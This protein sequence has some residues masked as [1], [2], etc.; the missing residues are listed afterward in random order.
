V[1][2]AQANNAYVFPA[3]GHAAV[4]TCCSSLPDTVFLEAAEKLSTLSS[5]QQLRQGQ[6]FPPLA[7]IRTTSVQLIAHLAKFMVA[8]GLGREPEAGLPV[9]GW[10]QLVQQQM[11]DPDQ[12]QCWTTPDAAADRGA[13][14]VQRPASRL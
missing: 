14:H 9:G 11:F 5:M 1:H 10:L 13:A 7:S 2:P 3:V 12:Q 6:L 8:A 4:L